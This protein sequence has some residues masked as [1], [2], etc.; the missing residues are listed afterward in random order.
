MGLKVDLY[1]Y[2]AVSVVAAGPSRRHVTVVNELGEEPFS[3]GIAE[4]LFSSA[5]IESTG[6]NLRGQTVVHT[7]EARVGQQSRRV[8]GI[9]EA[10]GQRPDSTETTEILRFNLPGKKHVT[11]ITY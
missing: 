10:L 4:L 11:T 6:R 3:S 5:T 8:C 7:G 2:S 9:T 1:R